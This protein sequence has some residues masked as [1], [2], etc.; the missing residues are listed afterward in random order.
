MGG[1]KGE[2]AKWRVCN[3]NFEKISDKK[4]KQL[5]YRW[6]IGVGVR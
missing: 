5:I 4:V 2:G 3:L 1:L 6:A